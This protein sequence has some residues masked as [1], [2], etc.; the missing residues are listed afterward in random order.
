MGKKDEILNLVNKNGGYIT[1]GELK[2]YNI[3]NYFLSSLVKENKLVRISR[4]YYTKV[5]GFADPFYILL[6]KC[7]KAIYSD[8]TA[9]Y[10]YDLSDRVPLV[11]DVTV[12]YGYG[13]CY[14]NI[15]NVSLH[16]VKPENLELGMTEIDSPFGMKIRV[17]DKE[18]TICDIIKNKNKMD[19]E[20][21]TKALQKYSRS[22]ERDLNKLMRYAKKLNID[23]KVREYMEVLL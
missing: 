19:M 8:A 4:G 21:F 18:R 23:K 22:K 5:D 11:Y 6:T 3:N 16:F 17:Y 7:R 13:N 9:L 12:P 15:D 2:Q 20:I 1:T 14:K 10:F